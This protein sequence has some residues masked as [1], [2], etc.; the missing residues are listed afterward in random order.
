MLGTGFKIAGQD[1]RVCNPPWLQARCRAAPLRYGSTTHHNLATYRSSRIVNT[2]TH[3]K[4]ASTKGIR[5][6]MAAKTTLVVLPCQ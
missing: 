4:Q 2:E 5:P 6:I 1:K 3:I